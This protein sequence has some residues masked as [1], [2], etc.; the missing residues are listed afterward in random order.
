[1]RRIVL[2]LASIAVVGA[3]PAHAQVIGGD[4]GACA[5]GNGPAILASVG[6]FKDRGGVLML[7]LYP[8]DAADF[9]APDTKLIAAGKVFRRIR[10][11]IP[12]SGPVELCMRV[13]RPGRYALLAVHDRDGKTKFNFFSDGAGF[14]GNAKL[15][16]SRPKVAAASIDVGQGVVSTAIRLQYLRGISG[17]GP[18]KN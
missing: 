9:L 7:E 1:M 14:P 12:A 13:P 6:G 17:F 11:G 5:V 4:A 18:L 3:L 16:M 15:G 8:A 2:A 10:I